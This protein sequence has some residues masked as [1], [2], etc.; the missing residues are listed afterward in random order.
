[1]IL[2][3]KI[4]INKPIADLI[5]QFPEIKEI[6]KSLGFENIINP[7]MLKTVGKIMTLK[8][9]SILKNI[10]LEI[11]RTKFLEHNFILEDTDE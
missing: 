3:N 9:G 2:I 10:D 6:M 5:S 4:N 7:I 11:I 8:K 1:M